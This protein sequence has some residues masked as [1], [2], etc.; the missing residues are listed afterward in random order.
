MKKLFVFLLTLTLVFAVSVCPAFA[1]E[2]QIS[3]FSTVSVNPGNVRAENPV[4]NYA[5]LDNMI[6]RDDPMA[7][8]QSKITPKPDYP[9]SH[10]YEE[11]IE[12]SK[13]YSMLLTIDENTVAAGYD[14]VVNAMY[15]VVVAMGMTTELDIMCEYLTEQGIRLPANSAAS[16]AEIAVV[17]AAIKYDAVYALYGKHVTFPKGTSLDGAV[18]TIVSALTGTVVPSGVDSLTGYGIHCTKTYVTSFSDLPVS[19]NPSTEE[20]FYWA[21]VIKAATSDYEVPVEVYELTTPAQKQYVDYAYYASLLTNLYDVQVNPV[22]LVVAMQSSDDL[23]LQKLILYSMLDESGVDYAMDMSCQELFDMACKNGW[24]ALE[25]EFYTDIMKYEIEVAQECTKIWFTPFPLAGVLS[26][27]SEEYLTLKLAGNSVAPSS[28]TGVVLDP[29]KAQ[30]TVYLECNYNSPD[31]NDSAVYEFLIIKNPALNGENNSNSQNDMVASVEQYVNS[32]VPAGNETASTIIDGVFQSVDSA[33]QDNTSAQVGEG[34]LTTY[35]DTHSAPTYASNEGLSGSGDR[36]DF[37][38]L[39]ELIDGVYA[40]DVNGNIV[41][42]P[43]FTYSEQTTEQNFI[44][45]TVEAVKENPE[46]VVAPTGVIAVGAFMGY[47]MNKKHRDSEAYL[48]N[49]KE[50]ETEE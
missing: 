15:Y 34:I 14:E 24:F 17:Y 9:Y 10:T 6:I 29:S 5:W 11:F 2:G 32:I 23:A 38:Y 8:L 30:E 31:R 33:V 39:E 28:T 37:D 13:N 44:E 42:S 35:A 25:E 18:V 46:V 3:Y 49:G 43:T 16:K 7:A 27:S 48:E 4:Y 40:T 21:K 22:K 36:F 50:T 41:T 19:E 45:K 20:I 26:G 47:L 12:E 1:S